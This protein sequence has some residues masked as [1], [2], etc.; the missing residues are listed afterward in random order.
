MHTS[1]QDSPPQTPSHTTRV[2]ADSICMHNESYSG[3]ATT[4]LLIMKF[5]YP[6]PML[7][8]GAMLLME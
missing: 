4:T 1:T 7:A 2:P 6:V 3:P 8:T 5:F